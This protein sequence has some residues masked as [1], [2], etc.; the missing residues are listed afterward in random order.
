MS[1]EYGIWPKKKT[2]KQ[3]SGRRIVFST[4][5]QSSGDRKGASIWTIKSFLE[6]TN[7]KLG[8]DKTF[9]YPNDV[10]KFKGRNHHAFFENVKRH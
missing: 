10:S 5:L 4:F 9:R 2:Q 6:E 7:Q 8:V 1:R 3:K